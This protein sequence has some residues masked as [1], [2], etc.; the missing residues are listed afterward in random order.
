MSTRAAAVAGLFYPRHPEQLQAQVN[1]LLEAVATRATGKSDNTLPKAAIVPHAGYVYSGPIAAAAYAR[2][3]PLKGRVR[4][5]VLVGPAHREA[6]EGMA[7]SSAQRF[8]TP[9]GAVAV[10]RQALAELTGL[11]VHTRDSAHRF[12]HSLEVQ[13]PFVQA[14]LGEV[15]IVPLLA[16]DARD[17]DV[18]R[19]LER[20]WADPETFI[21][22]SSDLSHY[23]DYRS[24]QR[25]DA[26]TAEAIENLRPDRIGWEHACG[27]IPIRGLL[28]CAKE[29]ALQ[30]ERVDLRNSGDTA[31]SR[32]RVVGYG[33]WLFYE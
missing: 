10:D 20:L 25:V 1:T 11:S 13:L 16:G 21:L 27:Q 6:F 19:V 17:V 29:R 3:R 23:L 22:I 30:V 15:A 5:V 24:A 9:L 28:A 18:A 8:V 26:Y 31:G 2:L 12:E 4:R 7:A 32:D 33:A 14:T